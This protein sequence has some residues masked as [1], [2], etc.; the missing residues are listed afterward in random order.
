[1]KVA[2]RSYSAIY[3]LDFFLAPTHFVGYI[4]Y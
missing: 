1:M 4:E 2:A 3:I